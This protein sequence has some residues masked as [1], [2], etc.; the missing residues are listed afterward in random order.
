MTYPFSGVKILSNY[1]EK[2]LPVGRGSDTAVK[3]DN[4]QVANEL[5]LVVSAF[6]LRRRF[7]QGIL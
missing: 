2:P 6:C 1:A 7:F 3:S 4:K 5:W